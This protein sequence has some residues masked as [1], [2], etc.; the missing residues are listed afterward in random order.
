MVSEPFVATEMSEFMSFGDVKILGQTNYNT[1]LT[2][3]SSYLLG[4]DLWD[5]VERAN[6]MEPRID[7]NDVVHK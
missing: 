1:W 7:T 4:Q 3:M 6:T 2:C 5:V